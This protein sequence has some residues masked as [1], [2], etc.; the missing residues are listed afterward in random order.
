MRLFRLLVCTW[1]LAALAAGQSSP[2]NSGSTY[3]QQPGQASQ[4]QNPLQEGQQQPGQQ[5]PQTTAQTTSKEFESGTALGEDQSLGEVRLM[6]RYTQI[7]PSTGP[8][9]ARSFLEDGSNNLAEFNYFIDR[10]WR[11]H[12]VQF[13]GM[14]R[15]TDD[16]SIDPDRNSIQKT[17]LRIYGQRDEYVFGDALVNYSRLTFNQ[18]IKGAVA[19][20]KFRD[21]WKVSGTGGVFIDRWSSLYK[22]QPANCFP[23][24]GAPSTFVVSTNPQCGRPFTAAVSGARLEYMF[25]R[26]SALGFN[27]SSYKDLLESRRPQAAGTTPQPAS[28][29]VGS[30]DLKLQ[31]SGLRLEAE[32]AYSFTNFDRR[33]LSCVTPPCNSSQPSPGLGAQGD[34]G[35]RFEASYRYKRLNVRASYL[36][37]QPN[38][39]SFNARQI[40]DLQDF[41]VR[42]SYDLTDWL[43]ADGTVRRSNDDLRKQLTSEK[44]LWGPEARLIFHDLPFYRRAVLE[45]GYRHRDVQ[46]SDRTI[47]RL[48]RIPYVELTLPVSTTFFT[49]GYEKRKSVDNLN[50]GQSTNTDRVYGSLRG[51]Y[52]WGGW[53][54]N[55]SLR[56]EIERQSY[57]P[58]QDQFLAARPNDFLNPTDLLF[59]DHDSNRLATASLYVEA[60]KWFIVELMFRDS[61]ATITGLNNVAV[62]CSASN[63]P[64]CLGPPQQTQ[65]AQVVPGASGFSRPSYRA[66]V[67]YKILNDENKV[68]IFS[69]ERHNNFFYAFAYPPHGPLN[70]N[71]FDE[72]IAGVTFVYKFGKRGR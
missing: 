36:R 9:R 25:R 62:P 52:D 64:P 32:Y 48:V 17:Y 46:A 29:Q 13:L 69:F 11:S 2:S 54:V 60:P 15:G 30:I 10:G 56:Y 5:P 42:T 37:Y 55:P 45:T 18:N 65:I 67:T 47:D 39:A 72:R 20:V 35:A 12:R 8:G 24:P 7:N 33:A 4:P 6:T 1:L 57:R 16:S 71:N 26:D 66:A 70:P 63:T 49:V 21:K 58:G 3:S 51:I 31:A 43:T 27:F 22:E 28:N 50:P 38:F 34:Y 44:V 40:A 23:P 14:Y 68:L 53:H 41:A 19:T 59:L 61:S